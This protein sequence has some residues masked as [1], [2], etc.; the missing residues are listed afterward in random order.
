MLSADDLFAFS[1]GDL[2]LKMGE[3][4]T[5]RTPTNRSYFG[6]NAVRHIRGQ[7]GPF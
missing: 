2:G 1:K 4:A 5:G 7:N 6:Q 3:I